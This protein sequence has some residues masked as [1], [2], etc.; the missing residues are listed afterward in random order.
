[1]TIIRLGQALLA[2]V[3]LSTALLNTA[4]FAQEPIIIG[5]NLELS[6]AAAAYGTPVA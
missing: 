3:L 4:A 5:G 2:S 6:G 1:M